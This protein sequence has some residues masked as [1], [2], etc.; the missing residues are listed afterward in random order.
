LLDWCKNFDKIINV[1]ISTFFLIF[2]VIIPLNNGYTQTVNTQENQ[3]EKLTGIQENIAKITPEVKRLT[4]QRSLLER[5]K[6]NLSE[7]L[8][9]ITEKVRAAQE[10]IDVLE[11]EIKNSDMQE[12]ALAAD[13]SSR[14][15]ETAKILAAMGRLSLS[16]SPPLGSLHDEEK[17]VHTAIILRNLTSELKSKADQLVSDLQLLRKMREELKENRRILAKE[18]ILLDS[19]SER[20][21]I[22]VETRQQNIQKTDK[23]LQNTQK[24][25]LELSK[26]EQTIQGLIEKINLEN[27]RKEEQEK[28]LELAKIRQAEKTAKLLKKD[29]VSQAQLQNN[30]TVDKPLN[31]ASNVTLLTESQFLS[32]KGQLS[33]PVS[34]KLIHQYAMADKMGKKRTGITIQ[35]KSNAIITS[36][37]T[38]KVIFADNF[39]SQGSI[40]ILNPVGK[41][42]VVLS[43]LGVINVTLGQNIAMG[44]PIGRMTSGIGQRNL[45]VEFRKDR[46]TMNPNNWLSHTT[47]TN[48]ASSY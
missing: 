27:K 47:K 29:T 14:K 33:R 6:V 19:D 23:T 31:N 38:A 16:P 46:S 30:L 28:A 18:Q 44:E 13:L 2:G 7:R 37:V 39:K 35:A 24:K 21:K 42:Y 41:Y 4:N 9:I 3:K 12:Q 45:Y 20:L 34:G 22:L 8:V 26:K 32:L 11:E 15:A 10:R 48:F 1:K 43:G 25:L 17:S 40:I 36:P 5:E